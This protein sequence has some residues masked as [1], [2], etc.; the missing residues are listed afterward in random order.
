MS[1]QQFFDAITSGFDAFRQQPDFDATPR[2]G[3]EP[4]LAASFTG[5]EKDGPEKNGPALPTAP[6]AAGRVTRD[7]A[8]ARILRGMADLLES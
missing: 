1:N 4:L 7:A 2:R 6:T 3:E 5:T 8:I